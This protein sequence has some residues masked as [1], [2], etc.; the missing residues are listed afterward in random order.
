MNYWKENAV[1]NYAVINNDCEDD[2][3]DE[4]IFKFSNMDN[5]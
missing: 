2:S 1:I 3:D 4:D 5:D